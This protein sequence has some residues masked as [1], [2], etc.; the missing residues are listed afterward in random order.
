MKCVQEEEEEA[1]V[2]KFKFSIEINVQGKPHP[3]NGSRKTKKAI[4]EAIT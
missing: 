1:M 3:I 2:Q 4:F